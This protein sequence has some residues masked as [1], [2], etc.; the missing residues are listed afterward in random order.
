MSMPTCVFLGPTVYAACDDEL[1][2]YAD[3]DVL[4]ENSIWEIS[5]EAVIPI[6]TVVLGIKCKD[7]G[8]LFGIV[9]SLSNGLITDDSWFCSSTEVP[10]WNLPGFNDTNSLFSPAKAGNGYTNG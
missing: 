10:G 7:L 8:G 5:K 6:D 9:A 1:T 2:V 4:I 3:G